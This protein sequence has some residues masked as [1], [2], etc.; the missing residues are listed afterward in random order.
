MPPSTA[1][2]F[3]AYLA[4]AAGALLLSVVFL[5]LYRFYRHRYLMDW[6]WSSWASSLAFTGGAVAIA[7]MRDFQFSHPSRQVV[8]Y[9][10]MVAGYWQLVWLLAGAWESG[11]VRHS[12]RRAVRWTLVLSPLAAIASGLL[13]STVIKMPEVPLLLR[14]A[15]AGVAFIVAALWVVRG[16]KAEPFVG[17]AV[18]AGALG[19]L[20]VINFHNAATH[21]IVSLLHVQPVYVTYLPYLSILL[22]YLMGLGVV[23]WLLEGERARALKSSQQVERLAYYDGLTGLPNRGLLMERLSLAL[24]RARA[25][26]SFTALIRLDLDR[27]KVVNDSLGQSVG[28]A[29]LW[30][31]AHRLRSVVRPEDTLARLG[32]DEFAVLLAERRS[33]ES[34]LETAHQLQESL[35][36]PFL[37]MGEEVAA[38]ASLGVSISPEAGSDPALL[39]KSSGV[40][41]SKASEAGGGAVEVFAPG[42]DSVAV[43]RLHLE[44]NLRKALTNDEFTLYYQPIFALPKGN[45]VGLEALL[46]WHHPERGLLGPGEFLHM[47][48][49]SGIAD[50]LDLWILLAAATRTR[51]WQSVSGQHL[52]VSVN[53]S[54]K[55]FQNPDLVARVIHVLKESGLEPGSLELEITETTAMQDPDSSREILRALQR[56]GVRVAIDDFG[57]GYSSLGAL[58]SLPVDTLKM[59]RAFVRPLGRD[60][61]SAAI[62]G[63]IVLLAHGLGLDVVGEGLETEPQRKALE[64]MGCDLVQGYLLARPMPAS[65][66]ERFLLE[67]WTTEARRSTR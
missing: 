31:V 12:S 49:A 18:T 14:M 6:V 43:E 51:Y 53:L 38:S 15:L 19:L 21:L 57:T 46:R 47:A 64:K 52:R 22:Q 27:F 63:S 25:S 45:V 58:Q 48:E 10:S 37:L 8:S 2:I 54:A 26:G 17:R 5:V 20:G 36:A 9:V 67:H 4:Q 60:E 30:S 65:E 42:M 44:S 24:A 34:V 33:R 39:M 50:A 32:G 23:M 40:A 41:L 29:L 66:C 1:L 11:G 61:K 3:S 62:A 7:I 28:D 35:H 13:F 56:V 59:D 16:W 55:P